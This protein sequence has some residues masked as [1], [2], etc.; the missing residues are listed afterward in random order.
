MSIS[1]GAVR[2]EDDNG[3][4]M[5]KIHAFENLTL[6]GFF[7]DDKNDMSWAHKQDEEFKEFTSSNA[8]GDAELLFGRV[9]Y[10]MM[11][12]FWPTPEAAKM[13]PDVAAGMNRMRKYVFSRSL[14]T[15]G[16]QNTTLLKRD[17]VAE[18]T[19][20]KREPGADL[21]VMGSGSIVSQLTQARLIDEYQIV[22]NPLVLGRGRTLFETVKDRLPLRLT[23]TRSFENGNVVLWYSVA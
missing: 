13:M 23:Q 8:R 20:L 14:G 10:E 2:V 22:L 11:A 7:T 9:T 17:P 3:G 5:R 6:D 21:V 4:V 19:R 15:A 18:A 1:L 16:W 12:S